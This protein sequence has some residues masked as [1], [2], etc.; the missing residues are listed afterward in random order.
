MAMNETR[1]CKKKKKRAV[2]RKKKK[3]ILDMG[4]PQSVFVIMLS[5]FLFIFNFLSKER[6]R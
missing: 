3:K 5:L 1:V 4:N 6:M 2:G